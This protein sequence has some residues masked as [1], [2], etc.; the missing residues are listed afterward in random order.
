MAERGV[1]EERA[2]ELLG[3]PEDA[4]RTAVNTLRETYGGAEGYLRHLGLSE[5]SISAVKARMVD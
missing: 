3:A 5:T 4:I 2:A 1:T